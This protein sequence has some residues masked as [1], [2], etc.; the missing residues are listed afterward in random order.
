MFLRRTYGRTYLV[1]SFRRPGD[2]TPR[3]RIIA[4]FG[5]LDDRQHENLL[6][7]L[8]ANSAGGQV[9]LVLPAPRMETT[10]TG[11]RPSANLR[12]LDLAVSLS[13]WRELGLDKLLGEILP[14]SQAEVSDADVVCALALQRL[15]DPGSKLLGVRWFPRTAL[16][17][18]LGVPLGQF[19]NTRLHRAL[20]ALEDVRMHLMGRLSS[21]YRQR[22][23][24]FATLFLDVTDTW[25]VGEGPD[26]AARG[27]T[28]EGRV[29]RKIGIVLLCN[30]DGFPIHWEVVCGTQSEAVTMFDVLSAVSATQWA[31]QSPLVVD[32]AMG[33]SVHVRRLL[34]L[35]IRFVTALK[36]TELPA[37][38]REFPHARFADVRPTAE[39]DKDAIKEAHRRA[40]EAKLEPVAENL[41]VK[42]LGLVTTSLDDDSDG[43]DDV[44]AEPDQVAAASNADD[45]D[46][47]DDM[48][49]EPDQVVAAEDRAASALR[50]ANAILAGKTSGKYLNYASA[51]LDLGL[52]QGQVRKFRPLAD[53]PLDIQEQIRRAEPG[54][55]S[56]GALLKL[57]HHRGN[58][59]ALREAFE[60]I[61]Q[62][63]A[64]YRQR[65]ASAC[66]Q[67]DQA[68]IR[69]RAILAFNPEM[70][71]QKRHAAQKRVDEIQRFV[72]GVNRGLADSKKRR[73][74]SSVL[75]EIDRRLRRDNLLE[76]FSVKVEA[77]EPGG[78]LRAEVTLNEGE[79]AR[80]RSTDGFMLLVA[81]PELK[82]SASEIAR[83]YRAKDAVEKSFET[84]KSVVQLRPVR[85]RDPHKVQA[86]VT[87][88]MLALL[89]ERTLR[90]KLGTAASASG[91]LEELAT[92]DLNVFRPDGAEGAAYLLTQPNAEQQRL[93]RVLGLETLGD[94]ALVADRITP[95]VD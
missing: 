12:Y 63:R 8:R 44:V 66:R 15:L 37:Y 81:H 61:P 86:H 28:K 76:A 73:A 47:G 1:E 84:I 18:L 71:V 50:W 27:K 75:A 17:E 33:C 87:L 88:C 83:L 40:V 89:L 85:H 90:K 91:A 11:P 53:L 67:S 42:D 74:Q 93:L 14:R 22:G 49:A 54:R 94:N 20:E 72:E 79:W 95:R 69:V 2:L 78:P 41:F 48:V 68:P 3:Q 82:A 32:R 70:L 23:G 24:A 36:K 30:E 5:P 46:G 13:I 39:G 52:T 77:P 64:R 10:G 29:E 58:P 80:R 26:F 57:C 59:E 7:A 34:A 65:G 21:L 60:A 62:P 4:G 25:F 38:A 16:P 9:A 31:S 51:G 45:S 92:C 55:Y 56:I 35:G 19:N 6:L 43:G